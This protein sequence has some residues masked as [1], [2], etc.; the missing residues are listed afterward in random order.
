MKLV[1]SAAAIILLIPNRNLVL[2]FLTARPNALVSLEKV[3]LT[4]SASCPLV[5]SSKNGD[6]ADDEYQPRKGRTDFAAPVLP[7]PSAVMGASWIIPA[8]MVL[9]T[10]LPAE[11]AAGPVP[12]ALWAYAHYLSIIIIFGCLAAEKTIV[13]AGMT[14][15]E[16]NTIVKLDLLYGVLAVLL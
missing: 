5:F 14:A 8:I 13:K 11:A 16:E 10:A 1:L 15:E 4:G 2:G 7:S 6:A 3:R 12:S 9:T